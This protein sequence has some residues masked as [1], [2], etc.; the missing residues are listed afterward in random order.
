MRV[1]PIGATLL[2]GK[3]VAKRTAWGNRVLR[4]ERNAVHQIW[5][6][7]AMPMNRGGHLELINNLDVKS[8]GLFR[9]ITLGAVFLLNG[10]H[11][12]LFAEDL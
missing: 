9:R 10:N 6:N 1:H 2:E 8:L 7:E 3:I 4:H 5:Q 11:V 12:H